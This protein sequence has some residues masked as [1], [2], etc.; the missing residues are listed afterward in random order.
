MRDYDAVLSAPFSHP[1]PKLGIRLNGDALCA[2]DFVSAK[3]PDQPPATAAA[4]R[5]VAQLRN[6]FEHPRAP[7]T[8]PLEFHGTPFQ[9][10]VWRALQDI[11]AGTTRSYGEL[12]RRLHTSARA[13][14]NACRGNP[15]AVIIPCHRIV[16]A[17]GLG[18][19]CGARGGAR[20]AVKRW[21]LAHEQGI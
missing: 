14:G 21:L 19:Y 3:H 15:I 17:H 16:A 9:E 13:V 7:F 8:L 4:R 10:K 6:Y 20:L 2:I 11:P 18:G 5:A 12:A 1:G